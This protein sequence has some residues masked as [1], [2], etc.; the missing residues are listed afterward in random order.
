LK[1][2][3]AVEKKKLSTSAAVKLSKASEEKQAEVLKDTDKGKKVKVK[4]VETATK[5]VA[6]QISSRSLKLK[7]AKA[8]KILAL[9]EE[10]KYWDG[11]VF[12]IEVCLGTAELPPVD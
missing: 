2:R 4:D 7:L 8:K 3:E 10:P 9:G 1:V 6:S 5:G 12:G 11:V